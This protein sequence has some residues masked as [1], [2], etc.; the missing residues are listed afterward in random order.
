MWKTLPLVALGHAGEGCPERCCV[1]SQRRSR[2]GAGPAWHQGRLGRDDDPAL[3]G[4]SPFSIFPLTLRMSGLSDK[5][6]DWRIE[7]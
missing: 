7:R 4:G 3:A 6:R 2:V 1:R 5:D